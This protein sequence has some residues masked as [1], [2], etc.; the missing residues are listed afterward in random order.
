MNHSIIPHRDDQ[1]TVGWVIQGMKV[2]PSCT[3]QL[4]QDYFMIP[5]LD[6]PVI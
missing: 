4:Y 2:L 6:Y 1:F 5:G 3:T